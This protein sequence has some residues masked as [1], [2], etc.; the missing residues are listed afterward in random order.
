MRPLTGISKPGP[1]A[2]IMPGEGGGEL[3]GAVAA[4]T[5]MSFLA[6]A[7]FT[8]PATAQDMTGEALGQLMALEERG[9]EALG[10][11]TFRTLAT[12]PV[13]AGADAPEYT[14]SWLAAQPEASGDA[15]WKC[16]SEALYFEARG[17]SVRGMFAVAEVIMNRVDSPDFPDTVC[18]VITQ[19][20]GQRFRCQFTYTCDGRAERITEPAAWIRVGKV[21]RA[22][23]DGAPRPLTGG[24]TYYHASWVSPAWAR[25]FE[26][27]AAIGVHYFYRPRG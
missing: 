11:D 4:A 1:R 21:A 24:A 8:A 18:G 5:V 6:L 13:A 23:L 22:M 14:E 25:R 10:T 3:A 12:A 17:E 15:E 26:R 16:L 19:G 27:T 9:L 2:R 7:G 20:T